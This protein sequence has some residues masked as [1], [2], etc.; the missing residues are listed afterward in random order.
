MKT[1]C[2][3]LQAYVCE[4]EQDY[5]HEI[6]IK[7]LVMSRI[8]S[9]L[10]IFLLLSYPWFC[11]AMYGPMLRVPYVIEEGYR[12]DRDV[13]SVYEFD[14]ANYRVFGAKATENNYQPLY[15][16]HLS[17]FLT[18]P[19]VPQSHSIPIPQVQPLSLWPTY[20]FNDLTFWATTSERDKKILRGRHGHMLLQ[21]DDKATIVDHSS[22][23]PRP[24]PLCVHTAHPYFALYK[25]QMI[26]IFSM[27]VFDKK[28]P[29]EE[30]Y[31]ELCI[32][33]VSDPFLLWHPTLYQFLIKQENEIVEYKAT[34]DD[35]QLHQLEMVRGFKAGNIVWDKDHVTYSSDGKRVMGIQ[36]DELHELIVD[37]VPKKMSIAIINK[38]SFK[39]DEEP[40]CTKIIGV[41]NDFL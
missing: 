9:K 34:V 20:K 5:K 12:F 37:A 16:V 22:V 14:G 3:G 33:N 32:S 38:Y 2:S 25:S 6:G 39:T 28:T 30:I 36:H 7:G 24:E 31:P 19:T 4:I 10:F 41:L 15:V 17:D 18:L 21:F 26:E 1:G 27:R 29:L 23:F 40:R 8:A 11:A 13:I 35:R